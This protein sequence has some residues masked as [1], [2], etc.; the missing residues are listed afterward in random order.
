MFVWIQNIL[1][2]K[3]RANSDVIWDAS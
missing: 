3:G 1:G 2:G